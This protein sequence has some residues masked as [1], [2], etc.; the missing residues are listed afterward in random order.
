MTSERQCVQHLTD[1]FR[2]VAQHCGV[3]HLRARIGIARN[4]DFEL[5]PVNLC[6]M[7]AITAILEPA[8]DGTLHVPVP[9]ELRHAKFKVV[10]TPQE[11]RTSESLAEAQ[12]QR[13]LFEIFEQLSL[14]NP[15][16][17][18]DPV[19][20]QREMREDRDLPILNREAR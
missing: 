2:W 10:A 16:G 7:S 20:W 15:F 3:G 14:S 8:A 19:S 5:M 11:E 18:L 6:I 1:L 12:R 4:L 13:K 9:L 17:G